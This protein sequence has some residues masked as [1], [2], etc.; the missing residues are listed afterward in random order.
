MM[1]FRKITF[2]FLALCWCGLA[3]SRAA[4]YQWSIPVKGARQ[5]GSRAFLWIPPNCEKVRGVVLAQHNMEEVSILEN[6]LFR[7]NLAELGF[8]EIWCA[9]AFDHLFRFNEG[10]GEIFQG[11]MD[12]LAEESGYAELKVAPIVGLGHS[13]AASWP[14]YFAAWNPERTLAAISV[15]GQW[16]YFRSSMF[17]PDIWG[18]RNIDYVPALETMGEYESASTFSK[19]GLKQRQEHP[20][21]PLSMLG[22]PAEGHFAST[23][24]KAEYLALYLRKAVQYRRPAAEGDGPAKLKPIDPTKEGWLVDKWRLDD[25]PAAPAAPVDKYTGDP[26][27]AF[28]HF[29]EE[30]ALATTKYQAAHRGQKAQLVGYVQNGEIVPQTDSHQQVNLKFQPEADGVTFKLVGTFLD[31]VPGGSP[32]PAKWTGLPAGLPIGHAAGGGPVSID[33]IC[34]P[35]VKLGPDTFAFRL[36]RESS[37]GAGSYDLWFAATHPGDAQFKPAVQQAQMRVPVPREGQEQRLTFPEIQEQRVGTKSVPL[38][39]SSDAGAKVY[40]YVRE[41]PAEIQGDELVF[42]QI[43][44][45]ARFPVKVTVVAWAPGRGVEPKLKTAVPVERTILLVR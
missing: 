45:R 28:W 10:A 32:R 38:S 36:Q 11:M 2:A 24:R 16:P 20:L 42:T 8:A 22:A 9:P 12:A 13:A 6:P 43:P 19:E 34:G 37:P 26:K 7:K 4:E 5:N 3:A 31:T 17:A 30:M 23:D 25:L 29:D 33:R 35:F 41:G 18:E 39:A 27:Q 44:P 15:S 14:Y 21:T 1:C 40:F